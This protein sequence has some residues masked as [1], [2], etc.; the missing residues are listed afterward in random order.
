MLF[1]R[2]VKYTG[3]GNVLS[4]YDINKQ[5]TTIKTGTKPIS[6]TEIK[7]SKFSSEKI[8]YGPYENIKLLVKV[9][10]QKLL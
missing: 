10:Q 5:T 9:G 6:F 4:V 7:P 2:F 3:F 1:Y 8:V